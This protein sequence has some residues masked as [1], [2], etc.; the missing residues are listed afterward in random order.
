MNSRKMLLM[1]ELKYWL[2]SK[3]SQSE[4]LYVS[5]DA[6]AGDRKKL[7]VNDVDDDDASWC[8]RSSLKDGNQRLAVRFCVMKC[9][10]ARLMSSVMIRG[11]RW[12]PMHDAIVLCSATQDCFE[13]Q[14]VS[15][16]VLV[17]RDQNASKQRYA[18]H[19]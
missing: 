17:W 10:F 13:T 15:A 9:T 6:N 4:V 5:P 11:A 14:R 2:M 8:C 7:R 18:P 1:C 3:L 12:G 19:Q 16:Q